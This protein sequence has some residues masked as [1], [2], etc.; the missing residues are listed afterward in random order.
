MLKYKNFLFL[1][2]KKPHYIS[3]LI[4]VFIILSFFYYK[5]IYIPKINLNANN[6]KIYDIKEAVYQISLI[7]IVLYLLLILYVS[8]SNIYKDSLKNIKFLYYY[9]IFIILFIMVSMLLLNYLGLQKIYNYK[10]FNVKYF[11]MIL[12]KFYIINS[13]LLPFISGLSLRYGNVSN[14]RPEFICFL[15][16]VAFLMLSERLNYI[17]IIF[18]ALSNFSMF[19]I[20]RDFDKNF[21]SN[22]G[23]ENKL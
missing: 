21:K 16:C 19:F 6:Y 8:S 22:N 7:S 18:L 4:A 2:L 20:E 1:I 11:S 14:K 13:A 10:Y 12:T 23:K 5:N 15:F 9:F 17:N 3:I